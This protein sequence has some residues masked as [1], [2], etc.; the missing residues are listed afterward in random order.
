MIIAHGTPPYHYTW[1]NGDTLSTVTGLCAGTYTVTVTDSLGGIDSAIVVITAPP[2]LSD[3]ITITH[4]SCSG[5]VNGT[6]TVH[7]SGGIP[8]YTFQWSNGQ[9]MQTATGLGEGTYS[10]TITDSNGCTLTDQ[11]SLTPTTVFNPQVYL[12]NFA[13]YYSY[14][15]PDSIHTNALNPLNLVVPGK[16]ARFK[17]QTENKKSNGLSMVNGHCL[18]RSDSPYLD[19]TDSLSNLNN[20]AWNSN[21][22]STDEFEIYIKPNTPAGTNVVVDFIVQE[23][24]DQYTTTCVAIPVNPLVYSATTP[25]PVS[26]DNNGDSD[27]DGNGICNPGET[28][29]FYPLL[30]S[31]TDLNAQYVKGTLVNLDNLS[32]I[33]IWDNQPGISGTVYHSSWWNY[34]FGQ[35]NTIPAGQINMSP[36]FDFVFD[37]S[38]GSTINDFNLY[39]IL[40]GGFRLFSDTTTLSL[41][42]W[43]LPYTFN[44]TAAAIPE[45]EDGTVFSIYPN[46][47]SDVITL[48]LS[49]FE[50][51]TYELKIFNVRGALVKSEILVQKLQKMNV[52]DL[53][54]GLYSVVVTSTDYTFSRRLIIQR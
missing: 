24:S 25:N 28:I 40:E 3:T 5:I 13:A 51:P 2:A 41:A 36:E 10:V 30:N 43:A 48:D 9:G 42:R 26:D 37:Y 45:A 11:V 12:T 21:A 19:I 1:S 54:N 7:A 23:N 8:P 14:D 34:A 17:I 33:T 16:Y 6:A 50:K 44:S 29:E 27:G 35:P 32:F 49:R 46:P 53:P 18:L 47:G 15:L 31:I 20:I 52:E 4:F 38:N 39:L 22:W